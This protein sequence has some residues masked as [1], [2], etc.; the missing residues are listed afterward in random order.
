MKQLDASK[1]DRYSAEPL[2]QQIRHLLLQA[3]KRGQLLPHQ[4]APSER[5]L[6]ELTGV[7]RMTV[8][9][10]LQQLVGDGWLYTV[11]GKGTFV[12]ADPKIEQNLQRL[13]GFTEEVQSQGFVPGSQIL[14]IEIVPADGRAAEVFGI[15]PDS[16]LIRICRQR[17]ANGVPIA[18]ENTHLVQEAFPGLDQVDLA[19]QS[20]YNVLQT[21]YAVYP[22]RAVQIIEA[23]CADEAT[24]VLLEIEPKK[25]VL[26]MERITYGIDGRPVE[27]VLSTYRADRSRLR[28]ELHANPQLGSSSLKNLIDAPAD[29]ITNDGN[30]PSTDDVDDL[31]NR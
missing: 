17:L 22:T 19:N 1:I 11:P 5:E 30:G 16:A 31:D 2:Y 12:A 4:Q 18:V 28:V 15:L 6:S 29:G 14:S 23:D 20:L 10:A 8:R 7:S 26:A 9:Q 27:Y 3:I 25:P 24:A 21:R 13:T